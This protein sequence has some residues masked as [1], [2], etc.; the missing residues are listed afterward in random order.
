MST[1]IGSWSN[2]SQIEAIYPFV[3]TEVLLVIAGFVFW[4]WWHV[5]QMRDENRE[6][7]KQAEYYREIGLERAMHHGGAPKIATEEEVKVSPAQVTADSSQAS[8]T[9]EPGVTPA[10][11]G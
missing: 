10:P 11:S 7:D 4:I 5:K 6:L 2:P 3:G 1:G 8:G 9:A